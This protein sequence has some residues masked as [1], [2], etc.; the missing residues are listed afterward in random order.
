MSAEQGLPV[1]S[2]PVF[3]YRLVVVGP[4]ETAARPRGPA[5][6]WRWLVGP[7]GTDPGSETARL[8]HRLGLSLIDLPGFPVEECWYATLLERPADAAVG[9][10]SSQGFAG[11]RPRRARHRKRYALV[12]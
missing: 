9:A 3:K 11:G 6:Q 2:E 8:L 10:R 12:V 1:V 5:R 4:G 7:S